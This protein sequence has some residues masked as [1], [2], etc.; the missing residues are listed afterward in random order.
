M[1][2][3]EEDK[4]QILWEYPSTH[5]LLN[6]TNNQ[7][8]TPLA[9]AIRYANPRRVTKLIGFGADF[10]LYNA[11]KNPLFEAMKSKGTSIESF[12]RFYQFAVW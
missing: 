11:N 3:L 7:G 6:A 5:S 4:L 9:I 1:F 12:P 2:E 8:H 10:S